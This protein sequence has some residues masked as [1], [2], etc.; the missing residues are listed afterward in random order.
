MR[1]AGGGTGEG[2]RPGLP[3]G[4]GVLWLGLVALLVFAIAFAATRNIYDDEVNAL[5]LTLLPIP[6]LWARANAQDVHPPG[7][8][9]L[10][11]LALLATGSVRASTAGAILFVAAGL[12]VF[13]G[14]LLRGGTL[15]GRA[16]LLFVG[17]A[18]LHPQVLMWGTSTRWQSYWTG[19]ALI[20]LTVGLA[21]H[22]EPDSRAPE[23]DDLAPPPVPV[24]L[25]LGLG[26]GAMLYLNYLTA[27][28]IPAIGLA[29]LLRYP[30]SRASLV[31]LAC[32][33]V[34]AFALF[35]P[36]LGPLLAVH[37]PNSGDQ[38]ARPL[39]AVL[40]MVPGVFAGEA[41]VPWH[42]I[43]PIAGVASLVFLL[44]LL[45]AARRWL[46]ERG[47]ATGLLRG[48][49]P[50]WLVLL[51]FAAALFTAA[52]V[53]GLGRKPR[54]FLL[55]GPV[56]AY[57]IALG[58]QWSRARWLRVGGVVVF[59]LWISISGY[60]L[61]AKV[62]AVKAG[63]NDRYDEVIRV[64]QEE[65]AGRTA[66]FFSH[67]PALAFAIHEAARER[68]ERWA[69]CGVQ[70]DVYHGSPCRRLLDA[71]APVD[72]VV[73]V[74]SYVGSFLSRMSRIERASNAILDAI[75]VHRRAATSFDPDAAMKRRL[76]G[77]YA[78][79]LPDHRFVLYLGEPLEGAK[80]ARLAE[81]YRS[82]APPRVAGTR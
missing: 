11:R 36:Q 79:L 24:S 48:A 69:V 64:A 77:P 44:P 57:P 29:W 52:V 8:Y 21:L 7:V 58:W 49:S 78:R 39:I 63:F 81:L 5:R 73:V 28:F 46:A 42:P 37:L 68:G 47:G 80:L 74:D 2:T 50:A 16:R 45:G 18:F 59:A 25:A 26:L 10:P 4:A 53:S 66:L 9:V 51:V 72:V 54:S 60:H 20:A 17:L 56:L 41:V 33:G 67:D 38:V 31:R 23:G 76:P 61:L 34:V 82:I 1:V 35:L 3:N 30:L 12:L 40:K 13:V 70:D 27:L 22:R 65:A 6:E 75:R 43:A 55:L 14:A 15:S 62:G 32:V 19:L 71:S